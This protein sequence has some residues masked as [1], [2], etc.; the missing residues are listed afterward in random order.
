MDGRIER[1]AQSVRE[2]QPGGSTNNEETNS[3]VEIP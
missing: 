1:E 3:K 2:A